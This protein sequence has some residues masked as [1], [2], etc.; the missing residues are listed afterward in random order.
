MEQP[1]IPFVIDDVTKDLRTSDGRRA[2][3][4]TGTIIDFDNTLSDDL[5][6]HA[7]F[8]KGNSQCSLY[9]TD[10]AFFPS[11]VYDVKPA[12]SLKIF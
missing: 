2:I 9:Q 10:T 1:A 4:R 3:L 12:T 7:H 11:P 8:C 6:I 5:Q